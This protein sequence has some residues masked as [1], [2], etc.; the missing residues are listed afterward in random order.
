MLSPVTP[1][2]AVPVDQPFSP[3][4]SWSM[5]ILS[6][7]SR[8]NLSECDVRGIQSIKRELD[9][10]VVVGASL[11]STKSSSPPESERPAPR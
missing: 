8:M 9:D 11:S 5:G 6:M 10:V 1:S 7:A 4:W 2:D 3:F